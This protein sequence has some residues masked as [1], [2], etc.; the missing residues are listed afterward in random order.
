[1]RAERQKVHQQQLIGGRPSSPPFSEKKK[2]TRKWDILWAAALMSPLFVEHAEGSRR[3][4]SVRPRCPDGRTAQRNLWSRQR[5]PFAFLLCPRFVSDFVEAFV[6]NSVFRL[7][8]Q[9]CP[10][11]FGLLSLASWD[12]TGSGT[13]QQVLQSS[14][15]GSW[16][17]S[18]S[19]DK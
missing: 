11:I 13:R 15:A 14:L 2:T 8:L 16:Q 3:S 10:L 5:E 18:D 12:A 7:C 6:S 4:P 17:R 1:M 19:A 9:V